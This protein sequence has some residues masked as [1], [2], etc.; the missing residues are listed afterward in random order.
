M[1][2]ESA[3]GLDRFRVTYGLEDRGVLDDME[4]AVI[5]VVYRANG[6]TTLDQTVQLGR[7]ME[8]GPGSRLLDIGTGCGWPALYL[9]ASTGC[10][11]VATDVP[12][13]GLRHAVRRA[14]VDGLEARTAVLA[15][16][17]QQPPFRDRSF[18]A[19]THTDVLC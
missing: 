14:A 7:M 1:P 6:Y 9:A 10:S 18:D 17:A 19:I 16:T 8:L 13:E 5:G 11:V 12:V 3:D 4:Q 15:S 2:D